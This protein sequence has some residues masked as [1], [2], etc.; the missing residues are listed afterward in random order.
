MKKARQSNRQK[1]EIEMG[2][3]INW[4][5]SEK[6]QMRFV[7]YKGGWIFEKTKGGDIFYVQ[8][9][10]PH[11][12]AVCYECESKIQVMNQKV[13]LLEP[14]MTSV[15]HEIKGIDVRYCPGCEKRPSSEIDVNVDKYSH[16]DGSFTI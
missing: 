7:E 12:K 4:E 15:V 11:A 8:G 10:D 16:L 2:G 3:S 6:R 5:F 9:E 1:L 14:G 13:S